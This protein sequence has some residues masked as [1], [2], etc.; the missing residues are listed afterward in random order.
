MALKPLDS[1]SLST[2][3]GSMATMLSAGIQVDEATLMLAE[4][5]G[6]SQFHD[7]CHQLYRHV[8]AGDS[9]S[10]AM[11][12]TQVFPSYAIDMVATGEKS[13]RTEQVLRNLEVY[14]E[15]E[16]RLFAKLRSSV[17]YPAALL[18]I[19]SVILAFTVA[20]I[21]PVFSNVYSNMAG[22]LSNGSFSSV[23]ISMT[24]GWIAL[25][26]MTVAA[27]IALL[28]AAV[29]GSPTGRTHVLNIMRVVPQTK[30]AMYQL[31]LS[32]FTAALATLIASSVTDEE[33]MMQAMET[34]GHP[35][36]RQRHGR[37]RKPA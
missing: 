30:N 27:I 17:G 10:V 21:L 19:M 11:N 1:S 28:L 33:A 2:F 3:C 26:I 13:G 4:N 24:I 6:R 22:S 7:V 20:V 31:S 25:A 9:L 18:V 14:Y 8:S 12:K 35:K 29:A 16:N 23:N 15:E 32:R 34:V 36:L 37:P 5:R